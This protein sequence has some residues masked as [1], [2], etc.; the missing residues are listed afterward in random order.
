MNVLYEGNRIVIEYEGQVLRV[1]PEDG[2]E[3]VSR[4]LVSIAGEKQADRERMAEERG[5]W[6]GQEKGSAEAYDEGFADGL[7]QR[8]ELP[9][10]D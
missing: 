7:S 5:Y 6:A 2:D 4:M 8:E 3:L 1:R 9:E 10:N